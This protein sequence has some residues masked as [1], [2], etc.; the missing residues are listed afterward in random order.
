M[1]MMVNGILKWIEETDNVDSS[2]FLTKLEARID[3]ISDSMEED[4]L[5]VNKLGLVHIVS[6][7]K[8]NQLLYRNFIS[9][10]YEELTSGKSVEK[11]MSNNEIFSEKMYV[12]IVP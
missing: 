3:V 12:Y 10:D 9:E 7:D 11:I 5:F 4:M 1:D 8:F 2:S 6:D